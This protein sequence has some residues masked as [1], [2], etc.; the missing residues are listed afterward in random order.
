[1]AKPIID[2]V[3]HDRPDAQIAYTFFSPSAAEFAESLQ[4]DVADFLPFDTPDAATQMLDALKPS[5]IVFSKLDVW[6]LLVAA[7]AARH[8]RLVLASAALDEE[9]GRRSRVARMLLQDA[10]AALDA[11]GAVHADDAARLVELGVQADRI[12]VTGDVR[13]DQV[14]ERIKAPSPNA[15]RVSALASERFTLVA[16]STWVGDETCLFDAWTQIRTVRSDARL[17]IAPHE[18]TEEGMQALESRSARLGMTTARLDAATPATDIV[19]VDRMGV[20]AD[21][22]ALADISYVGGGFHEA[23]LHSVVEPAAYGVPV[24]FGP[25]H[26]ASRDAALL[27][28]AGGGFAVSDGSSLASRIAS[29]TSDPQT[30]TRASEGARGV[31]QSGLGAADKSAALI[32]PML[33]PLRLSR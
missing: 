11:V 31:I 12:T 19:V 1:M 15:E 22:Y 29:L 21:L 24:L 6:P 4:V 13:Y 5:V 27:I 28:G 18:L 32:L 25:Q 33:R 30:Q 9:S 17:I 23:G 14:W 8:V 26:T 10:Y 20:L 3:R 2:R 7:A 16:G